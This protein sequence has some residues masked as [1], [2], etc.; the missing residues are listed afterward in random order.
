MGN[1][2]IGRDES[3]WLVIPPTPPAEWWLK[4]EHTGLPESE[5]L[6]RLEAMRGAFARGEGPAFSDEQYRRYCRLRGMRDLFFLG[7]WVL[8]FDRLQG[9]LHAD[10]AYAWQC[11]DGIE[12][13]R[14]PAGLFRWA[15]IPRGHL[16]TTILTI[17]YAIWLLVRDHDERILIYS[18]NYTLAKK[19]FGLIRA[20][21]EGKGAA[22]AF[23][24]ECYPELKTTS[25]QRDK[26]KWAE[27]ALTIPR[28]TPFTDYSLECSGIDAKISGS[29]FTTEL[30]DDAVAKLENAEQMTKI[31]DMLNNL[32]P[33]LDSFETGKRRM[34]CTPWGFW[35]PAARAERNEAE[36]LVCRRSM[37]EDVDPTAVCGRVPITDPAKFTYARLTY[38]WKANM[39]RTIAKAKK[40][41]QQTPYFFSCQ[42][43]CYPKR[44]GTLG[45]RSEWFRRF[46]RRGD[47]LVELGID[48]REVKKLPLAACN[49]FITVD[50]IGGDRRGTYGPADPNRAPSMDTD[51][52]G[53]SVVAVADDNM[54]YVLDVRRK[55]Y[56]DDEFV[57]VIF[58][59][60]AYYH[61]RS[62]HIEATA[63]QRHIFKAFLDAWRRGKP[64]FVLGEWKG[65]HA[66]KSERIRGLIPQISEGF[67]L[68]RTEAPPAIQEG[69][70]DC[71]QELLD[72]ETSQ[73]DDAK[74]SLSA[75]LQIA[76][77][78]GQG[79]EQS[80]Q[81]SLHTLAED[82]ELARL[83]PT[84]RWAWDLVRKKQRAN[85][86]PFSLGEGFN[87]GGAN[88]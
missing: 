74:D 73:H 48:A 75:I 50:P 78:P 8:G 34:A 88:A 76:Y 21:L 62:V 69:I 15:T 33:L 16:K 25:A 83:D 38:R 17:S 56:N 57:T 7:K 52:V 47:V 40:I 32:D 27:N 9:E 61:P 22:G 39:D 41:A 70:D 65:G 54:K 24:L 36:A 37:F 6:T 23:F 51:Y 82:D 85:T 35:D 11:P 63:G 10:L 2:S 3:N 18:A 77:P 12:L 1:V 4:P 53:I 55:R 60:V 20:L 31:L 86:S 45:F 71:M 49:V 58:D 87:A 67:M 81:Q 46:V 28:T 68:F 30:V 59:L 26:D 64:M 44:E 80:Y 84:S 19:I 66:S 13:T 29:H 14:G 72:G 42:F 79:A 43:N 5:E